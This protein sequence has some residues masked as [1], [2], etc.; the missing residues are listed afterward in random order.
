M[1]AAPAGAPAGAEA[2]S[3]DA[4]QPQDP[5]FVLRGHSAGHPGHGMASWSL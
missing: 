4:G 5:E 2:R 1:S 3:R